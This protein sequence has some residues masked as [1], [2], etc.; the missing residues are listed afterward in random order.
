MRGF[1]A[2]KFEARCMDEKPPPKQGRRVMRVDQ[3]R[4]W[5]FGHRCR[6]RR[7]RSRRWRRHGRTIHILRRALIGDLAPRHRIEQVPKAEDGECSRLRCPLCLA[8]K[9]TKQAIANRV[10]SGAPSRE[11]RCR[12]Q[13]LVVHAGGRSSRASRSARA[14]PLALENAA[15]SET[16]P[17]DSNQKLGTSVVNGRCHRH[18][19]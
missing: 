16:W 18:G 10:L 4:L 19:Q 9:S 12:L 17:R 13:A 2:W 7:D 11:K 15:V 5:L 3:E 8:F 14:A 1:D 6:C